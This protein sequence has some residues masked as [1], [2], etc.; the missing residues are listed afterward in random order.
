MHFFRFENPLRGKNPQ[1]HL[2]SLKSISGEDTHMLF[3]GRHIP[4]GASSQGPI[5]GSQGPP[6][7]S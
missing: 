2:R 4:P 7:P 1:E 5:L 6:G 3:G